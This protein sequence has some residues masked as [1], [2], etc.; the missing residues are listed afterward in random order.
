MTLQ[1]KFNVPI[2]DWSSSSVA[3]VFVCQEFK[4]VDKRLNLSAGRQASIFCE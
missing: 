2:K 4:S 1:A 3:D